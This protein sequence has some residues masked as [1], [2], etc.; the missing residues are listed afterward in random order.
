MNRKDIETIVG[1][2][3]LAVAV[4]FMV[5]VQKAGHILKKDDCYTV[6]AVFSRV[7]GLKMSSDV[8]IGGI[9]VGSITDMR[10]DT[11]TYNVVISM[12]I[13]DKV[14]LS[15]DT[16]AQVVGTLFGDKYVTLIPGIEAEQLKAGS[17]IY[18][19]QSS[20]NM[21]ALLGKFMFGDKDATK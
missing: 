3:V 18:N 20:V 13:S 21:E 17:K 7:D 2:F 10:L 8:Q 11:S 4:I 15:T 16:K 9:S 5:I 6:E 1:L 12:C 14:E 19:T